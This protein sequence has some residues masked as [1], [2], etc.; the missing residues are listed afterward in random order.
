MHWY[1]DG[2]LNTKCFHASALLRE[3]LI[4]S[5]FEDA[6]EVRAQMKYI[7]PMWPKIH[8]SGLFQVTDSVR[9]SVINATNQVI[10]E[11]ENT[12]LVVPFCV[13]EFKEEMFSLLADKCPGS[14][15]FNLGFYQH[16]WQICS[17][18]IFWEYCYWL[19]NFQISA[20]L[21]STNM[22]LTPKGNEWRY[23]MDCIIITLC[24]LLYEVMLKVFMI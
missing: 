16:F 6:N 18:D 20:S 23:M 11:D 9:A 3:K 14:K 2:D 10:S 21:N 4:L 24:N 12:Y 19:T 15:G 1:R 22:T 5:Y 7:S 8:F 13:E 17:F